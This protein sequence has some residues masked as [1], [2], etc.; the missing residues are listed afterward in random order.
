M[1]YF[2][3]APAR[4]GTWM[5]DNVKD[6]DN[7]ETL[8]YDPGMEMVEV[9]KDQTCLFN[10][11]SQSNSSNKTNVLVF[12]GC[13]IDPYGRMRLLLRVT[14]SGTRAMTRIRCFIFQ[15]FNLVRLTLTHQPACLLRHCQNH[16]NLTWGAQRICSQ[17]RWVAGVVPLQSSMVGPKSWTMSPLFPLKSKRK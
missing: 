1:P 8:P 16:D 9:D 4:L 3:I 11:S 5:V 13:P 10:I 15:P 7:L 14:W 6:M 2:A 12:K 17:N